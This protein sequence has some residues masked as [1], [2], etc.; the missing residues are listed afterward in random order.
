M[1]GTRQT[2]IEAKLIKDGKPLPL[3]EVEVVIGEEKVTYTIKKPTRSQSGKYQI[4]IANG[5]G[6]DVK[7]ININMQGNACYHITVC[8]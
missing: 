4:K 3:K 5:Q 6:E 8:L 1:E 2:P 7:N